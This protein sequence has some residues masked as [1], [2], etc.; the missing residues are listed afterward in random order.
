[1][2]RF[3]HGPFAAFGEYIWG[4]DGPVR[5]NGWYLETTY[6]IAK[7]WEGVFRADKFSPRQHTATLT[8]VNNYVIGT[9]FYLNPY[10]TL[11]AN[12]DRQED[13]YAK[14]SG[15]IVLLQTQFQFGGE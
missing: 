9:N 7:K 3:D 4:H 12:Y 10:V 14:R 15:N 6:R 11:E 8:A 1:E 2:F 5:R 13:L